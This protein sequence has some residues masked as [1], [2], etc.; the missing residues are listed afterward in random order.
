MKIVSHKGRRIESRTQSI[1]EIFRAPIFYAVPSYQRDFAWT[2]E[3]VSEMWEDL[4]S[5]IDDDR[6]EYF[7]GTMVTSPGDDSKHREV[8]DGQ[9]DWESCP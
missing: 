2:E 6:D 8:V 4:T 5:A 7:L 3:E 9:Q 1:G